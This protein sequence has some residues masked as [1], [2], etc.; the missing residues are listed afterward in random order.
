M[1]A[2]A[3]DDLD[4]C[5][6]IAPAVA[7]V[8][9]LQVECRPPA[10]VR[11]RQGDSRSDSA[12]LFS[13]SRS[14]K[15]L[16]AS[17]PATGGQTDPRGIRTAARRSG[18]TFWRAVSPD[19]SRKAIWRVRIARLASASP[20][21]SWRRDDH[22]L[23]RRASQ[24]ATCRACRAAEYDI[25]SRRG[26]CRWCGFRRSGAHHAPRECARCR[27]R[28]WCF[29]IDGASGAAHYAP[30]NAKRVYADEVPVNRSQ[31]ASPTSD[32]R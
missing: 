1:V 4:H 5:N 14:P 10:D 28:T 8:G 12:R 21:W 2:N 11:A 26:V 18:R 22:H 15:S 17:A 16:T 29:T 32:D 31:T 6:F 7:R 23:C 30:T 20:G 9:S 19:S 13:P 25:S 27:L 24:P 3:V